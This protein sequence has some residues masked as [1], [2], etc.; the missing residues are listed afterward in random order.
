[1]QAGYVKIGDIR[2]IAHYNSKMSTVASVVNLVPG[3]KFITL[4]WA[5]TFV[6]STFAVTDAARR[7]GSSAKADACKN[8]APEFT[9]S[10]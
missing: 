9:I 3:R 4:Q 1:M 7:A 2:Q 5:S 6:S 8:N 10:T